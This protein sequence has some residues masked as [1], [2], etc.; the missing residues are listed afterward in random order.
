MSANFVDD[1]TIEVDVSFSLP[2]NHEFRASLLTAA[3]A[4][5]STTTTEYST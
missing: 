5:S 4:K 3:S 2:L 1:K